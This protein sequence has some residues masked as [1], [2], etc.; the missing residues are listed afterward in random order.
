MELRGSLNTM[1]CKRSYFKFNVVPVND[2]SDFFPSVDIWF[3]IHF[4]FEDGLHAERINN[5]TRH[6]INYMIHYLK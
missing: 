5:I 2:S 3:S 6:L 1:I 4:P